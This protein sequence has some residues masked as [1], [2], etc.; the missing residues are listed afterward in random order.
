MKKYRS[1]IP[2]ALIASLLAGC[3][4]P[5]EKP[6]IDG[7]RLTNPPIERKEPVR[8]VKPPYLPGMEPEGTFKKPT[9][10]E[11]IERLIAD[12]TMKTEEE[13]AATAAAAEGAVPE[14]PVIEDA[15]EEIAEASDGGTV[16]G[17]TSPEET[18]GTETEAAAGEGTAE[19]VAEDGAPSGSVESPA[20]EECAED[21]SEPEISGPVA[22]G[23][24]AAVIGETAA[25]AAGRQEPLWMTELPHAEGASCF[26]G[27]CGMYS[28]ISSG[29]VLAE[30]DA[31][32]EAKHWMQET[33]VR[34]AEILSGIEP[35]EPDGRLRY[36]PVDIVYKR[37]GYWTDDRSGIH[38]LLMFSTASM[39][40]YM[41][42][43]AE[44][45]LSEHFSP[46]ELP[47]KR[48]E[49]SEI[50]LERIEER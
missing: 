47:A 33:A 21:V 40:E 35:S 14:A 42:K 46:E 34:E 29:L 39:N 16:A 1:I 36:V 28:K 9:I 32:E 17:E 31:L 49:L 15:S 10:E 45:V 48:T 26:R 22:E 6:V 4:T 50:L 43:A 7:F 38:V 30:T 23:M 13:T 18:A 20:I 41:M 25:A 8:P 11:A 37:E 24:E 12:G 3:A 27:Y 2:I 44:P 5:Y 19:A